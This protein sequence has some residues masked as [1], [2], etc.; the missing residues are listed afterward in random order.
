MNWNSTICL[1]ANLVEFIQHL[2]AQKHCLGTPGAVY[3]SHIPFPLCW[4]LQSSQ[5]WFSPLQFQTLWQS[6]ASAMG[7]ILLSA[8]PKILKCSLIN[9]SSKQLMRM[10][11]RSYA[12]WYD[13]VG[14]AFSFRTVI[15]ELQKAF[16]LDIGS[17]EPLVCFIITIR[18]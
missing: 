8:S 4:F 6:F 9:Q 11:D 14:L 16:S 7:A 12:K 10:L 5:Q 1:V 3:K 2:N 15:V 17:R 18:P 13:L